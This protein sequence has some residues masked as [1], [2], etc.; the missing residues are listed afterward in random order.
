MIEDLI[1]FENNQDYF[2][3]GIGEILASLQCDVTYWKNLVDHYN[4]YECF[5]RDEFTKEVE[6]C[7]YNV[8]DEVE[9]RLSGE[10]VDFPKKETNDYEDFVDEFDD[11][12]AMF[13][14]QLR[15]WHN[16]P[17]LMG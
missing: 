6:D 2:V 10:G 9:E 4:T 1:T 13:M 11:Y 14:W 17:W 3:H 5:D 16:P 12:L 7:Y 8:L 15:N